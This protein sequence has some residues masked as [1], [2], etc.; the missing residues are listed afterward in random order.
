MKP[1]AA[2]S[3]ISLI[4]VGLLIMPSLQ[5]ER[6]GGSKVDE[7]LSIGVL[8]SSKPSTKPLTE[9][10]TAPINGQTSANSLPELFDELEVQLASADGGFQ[11]K[12]YGGD[13]PFR[14]VS[15]TDYV[16]H[17]VAR[18]KSEE[19]ENGQGGDR[20][21]AVVVKPDTQEVKV[22]P[23]YELKTQHHSNSSL[24]EFIDERTIIFV[25]PAFEQDVF[26][27]DLA[28]L[29]IE[30]GAVSV[31]S[32]HIWEISKHDNIHAEDFW[33]SAHVEKASGNY[34]EK[35]LL[36]TFKGQVLLIDLA[37]GQV[38]SSSEAAYPAYGDPGSKPPRELVFPSP[39]L[40]SLVYQHVDENQIM[41]SN[42]FELRHTAGNQLIAS[43]EMD[44]QLILR[45]PGIEWDN[46]SEMFI[47]EYAKDFI[48]E[49]FDNGHYVFAEGIRFFDKKGNVLRDLVIPENSGQRLNA[50]GW[51]EDG[52][53]WVEYFK[54]EGSEETV[55]RKG[56]IS[57]KLYDVQSGKLTSFNKTSD[58]DKLTDP[59]VVKRDI[60]YGA[61]PFLM[62]DYKNKLVWEPPLGAHAKYGDDYL[63][64]QLMAEEAAHIQRWDAKSRSWSWMTSETENYNND[65]YYFTTTHLFKDQWLISPHF[66]S[67][68]IDYIF[69]S[70]EVK[71]NADGLPVLPA[72]FADERTGDEWWS[73]DSY[74]SSR[75]VKHSRGT[76]RAIGKSRYG[77]IQLQAQPGERM[78]RN[79]AQ[80]NYYGSYQVEMTDRA[81][82][83]TLLEPLSDF[84]LRQEETV[85]NMISY[86]F[87]GYD[88]LL[89]Q[90][91]SYRFSKG[92]DGNVKRV[93]AYAITKEGTAFPLMFQYA[94]D[95]GTERAQTITI[96]DQAAIQMADGHL[97][98]QSML[99]D[100]RY[101][102][103]LKPNL[104]NQTLTV[105]DITDRKAEYKE[106]QHIADRYAKFLEQ[107]L[108]LEDIALPDGRMDEEQLRDLFTDKAWNNA[109]F[110]YLKRDFAKSKKEGM[111]SR[112]FAWQP[113]D[114][115]WAGPDEIKVTY[116]LNL[117]YAIGLAAHLEA[118][119]KLVDGVW[120]FWD[121]GILETEKSEDMPAYDGLKIVPK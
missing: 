58:M 51:Q 106:L 30:T 27:Y 116:T 92:F 29:N 60:S 40:Q 78:M 38:K 76:V 49:T 71:R 41:I 66:K 107:A 36:S 113:I 115:K 61:A 21:D 74:R 111:P 7:T 63:Y 20:L 68:S 59:V 45:S 96:N 93:L 120:K 34:P 119:M 31:I 12:L 118:R 42:Q 105:A 95:A 25:K 8:A 112:A 22:F 16:V 11:L 104:V 50:F 62:V 13:Y 102:L 67:K 56:D 44:E 110:Q 117:W 89:L 87:D 79:G 39:D 73:N 15:T 4:I 14:T 88:V 55:W 43:F 26:V 114:A 84:G 98:I 81:G 70:S 28:S 18:Y 99:G 17:G 37:S 35:L 72:A 103:A 57:Y 75:S 3:I 6:T 65:P 97:I 47:L 24:F 2:I 91:D 10:M 101:E 64:I 86:A 109:G 83:K 5:R 85:S 108:G 46:T 100:G 54:P 94:A 80:H 33:L 1:F 69:M 19:S 77:S 9:H 82:Q 121:F 23:L 32:P 52:R 48:G 90:P 53:L